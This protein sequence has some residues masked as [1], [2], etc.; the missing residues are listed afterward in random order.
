M[1]RFF[2]GVIKLSIGSFKGT[3][4]FLSL[5]LNLRPYNKLDKEV[6]DFKDL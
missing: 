1:G 3:F 2:R 6:R 4:K 5:R